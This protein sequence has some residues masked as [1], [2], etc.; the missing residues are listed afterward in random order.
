VAA[1]LAQQDAILLPVAWTTLMA[2][3]LWA[4]TGHSVLRWL[5]AKNAD[6]LSAI[7]MPGGAAIDVEADD[8]G[9]Q[10]SLWMVAHARLSLNRDTHRID[11]LRG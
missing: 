7:E 9:L 10:M 5:H 4:V 11:Q 6:S 2:Y 3:L 8:D 1:K